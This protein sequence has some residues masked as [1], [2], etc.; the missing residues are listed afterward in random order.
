MI[1]SSGVMIIL[2]HDFK[3]LQR[4]YYQSQEVQM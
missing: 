1:T 4:W 2:P 3:H